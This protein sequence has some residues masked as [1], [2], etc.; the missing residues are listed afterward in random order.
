MERETIAEL[1]ARWSGRRVLVL[2]DALLDGWLTGTP[3]RLCREAPVG[4]VELSDSR[5]TAGGAANTATNLAALGARVELVAAT[6][7]DET[8]QLLSDR[9]SDAGVSSRLVPVDGRRTVT[10]RRLLAGEQI[11]ARFDEGDVGPLP[12]EHAAV[13]LGEV[14]SVLED[15]PACVVVCDY[16]A[17]T[18]PD[19]LIDLL[20]QYR[21]E[22]GLLAVDAHDLRRWRRTEP[23]L[24]TPNLD[25]AARLLGGPAP[26]RGRVDWA[27]ERLPAVREAAGARSVALTLDVDGSLVLDEAGG[28]YRTVANPGPAAHS[29]GAGDSYLAGFVLALVAGAGPAA[30]SQVA[31]GAA[32]LALTEPGTSVCG[33]DVL[34]DWMAPQPPR[35]LDINDLTRMVDEARA[36]GARIVFTNGCFDVLHRGHIGYLVQARQLGEVLI[37]AVNSDES[38]RRLKGPGRPVNAQEDRAGVLAALGCVDHVIIFDDDSPTDLLEAIRPDVYVKGGDYTPELIPEAELVYAL[39][40]EVQ[41]LGYLPDRSTS[42]II[43][44]IRRREPASPGAAASASSEPPEAGLELVTE[45][46]TQPEAGQAPPPGTGT[47]S[48]Q[49]A[50]SGGGRS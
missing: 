33:V 5:Y 28:L 6:G 39:G 43:E 9:L 21:G 49:P 1:A 7:G 22:V 32:G 45:A 46:A 30:A 18:L 20:C 31:Q 34:L 13:L 25:E 11:V 4:V 37:V 50:S 36:V 12:P 35:A 24:V 2:G 19:E 3:D 23:D 10:K 41:T 29:A 17:G 15:G 44:R 8:A 42:A 16:A 26:V 40:G 38:V 14:R 27:T 48:A 47:T